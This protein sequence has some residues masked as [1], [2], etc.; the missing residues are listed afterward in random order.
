MNESKFTHEYIGRGFKTL[1]GQR[2][3]IKGPGAGA[4]TVLVEFKGGLYRQV[5]RHTI[6][7]ATGR[8]VVYREE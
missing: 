5:P 8:I 4:A 3:R 7:L 2:C 6:R 1:T